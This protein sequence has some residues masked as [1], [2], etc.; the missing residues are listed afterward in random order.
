MGL[1]GIGEGA[2]YTQT[3]NRPGFVAGRS[4]SYLFVSGTARVPEPAT[5]ATM[6]TGFGAMGLAVRRR[7]KKVFSVA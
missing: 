1:D 6:I 3:E 5:W 7:T 2:F 4:I